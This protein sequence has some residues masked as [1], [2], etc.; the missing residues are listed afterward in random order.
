MFLLLQS[1]LLLLTAEPLLMLLC[2]PRASGAAVTF[3]S[4]AAFQRGSGL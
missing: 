1:L 3:D 2:I 4:F